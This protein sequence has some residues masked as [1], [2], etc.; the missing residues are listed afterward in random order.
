MSL[1]SRFSRPKEQTA[2]VVDVVTSCAHRDLAPRWDNAADMGKKDKITSFACGSC[3]QTF[4][5][6]EA[7]SLVTA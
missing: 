4:T 6:D 2:P 5:P 1:L 7:Q 3:K